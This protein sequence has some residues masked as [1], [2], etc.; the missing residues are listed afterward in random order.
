MKFSRRCGH[1][2]LTKVHDTIKSIQ[3]YSTEISRDTQSFNNAVHGLF[4]MVSFLVTGNRNRNKLSQH[5]YRVIGCSSF[6]PPRWFF[7]IADT[8][9]FKLAMIDNFSFWFP[10]STAAGRACLAGRS[11]QVP[12][13]N[14]RYWT[15]R[16]GRSWRLL[17]TFGQFQSLTSRWTRGH[18]VLLLRAPWFTR[19]WWVFRVFPRCP[20]SIF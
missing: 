16:G 12:A 15:V 8:L 18:E 19:S 13:A 1:L 4:N 10:I 11:R 9:G 6:Y 20:P 2:K 5:R 17:K 3:I 7:G 14:R